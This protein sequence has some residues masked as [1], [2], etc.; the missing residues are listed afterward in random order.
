MLQCIY[1][2]IHVYIAF[3]SVV[4][5]IISHHIKGVILYYN[6]FIISHH[7]ISYCINSNAILHYTLDYT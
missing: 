7:V 6:S 1:I 4:Y 2:Y 3:C 5:H